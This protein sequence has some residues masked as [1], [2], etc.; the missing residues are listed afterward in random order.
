M[1]SLHLNISVA[2]VLCLILL[3]TLTFQIGL[4]AGPNNE[5]NIS[6]GQPTKSGKVTA[7][8]YTK[9]N[10]VAKTVKW[11]A[12]ILSTD[13]PEQKAKKIR[14]AAPKTNPRF[15]IQP[16]NNSNVVSAKAKDGWTI[17]GM[18]IL[19][20][21]T[22][23]DDTYNVFAVVMNEHGG[24]LSLDSVATGL[25]AFGNQGYVAVSL[26]LIHI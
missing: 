3:L 13:T 5:A 21:G 15:T 14:D 17:K 8:V 20:D 7:Y 1:K 25:D 24:L 26:S 10:G 18:G 11:S 19:K 6:C 9:K 2:K 23:E 12:T 4:Y 16:A 22:N